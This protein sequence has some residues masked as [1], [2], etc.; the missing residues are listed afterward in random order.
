MP[1]DKTLD[2]KYTFYIEFVAGT[3]GAFYSSQKQLF[4]GCPAEVVTIAIQGFLD[5]SNTDV[6]YVDMNDADSSKLTR[7]TLPV[8][9]VT[10]PASYCSATWSAKPSLVSGLLD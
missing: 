9:Q 1:T 4:V 2:A 3:L 8:I 7:F 5:S 6:Q 10:S